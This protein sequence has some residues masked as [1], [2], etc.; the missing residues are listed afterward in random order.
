MKDYATETDIIT[1]PD[2]LFYP[3]DKVLWA[4]AHRD[5]AEM[6]LIVES[7]SWNMLER[8][9]T[10]I[11]VYFLTENTHLDIRW[12]GSLAAEEAFE[13]QLKLVSRAPKNKVI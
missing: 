4:A 11:L 6:P 5:H 12:D 7:C 10:Y 13:K 9:W 2:P 3:G 1:T 8:S